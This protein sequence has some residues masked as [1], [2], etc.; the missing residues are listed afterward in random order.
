MLILPIVVKPQAEE[1]RKA[2]PQIKEEKYIYIESDHSEQFGTTRVRLKTIEPMKEGTD[3]NVCFTKDVAQAFLP[4]ILRRGA[5]LRHLRQTSVLPVKSMKEV[6]EQTGM[7]VS[8]LRAYSSPAF[9]CSLNCAIKADDSR[10]IP[11][12]HIRLAG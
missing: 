8:Q 6:K 7:S 1:Q 9:A 11:S 3:K 5:L 2:A 4:V 10:S 12:R